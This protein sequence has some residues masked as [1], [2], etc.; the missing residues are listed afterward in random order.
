LA[1]DEYQLVRVVERGH[2]R[3]LGGLAFVVV[4]ERKET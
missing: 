4:P 2:G 3:V 1:K